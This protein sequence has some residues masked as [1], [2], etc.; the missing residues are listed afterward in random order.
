M[1]KYS[2]DKW[3]DSDKAIL[4]QFPEIPEQERF[5]PLESEYN[6]IGNPEPKQKEKKIYAKRTQNHQ[7]V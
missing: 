5:I 7:E 1:A 3:A 2:K 4:N 6:F